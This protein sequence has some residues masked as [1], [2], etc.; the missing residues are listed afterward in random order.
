[1]LHS[2]AW[3]LYGLFLG[4]VRAQLGFILRTLGA[5]PALVPLAVN[6]PFAASLLAVLYVPWFAPYRAR[7]LVAIPRI[8][9]AALLLPAALCTGPFG[10]AV[11]AL[12]A[13]TVHHTAD[14]FYGRLL[15]QL[16][17]AET[18]GRLLSLPLL[19]QA[20]AAA[21]MALAAGWILRDSPSAYRWLVPAGSVLGG[22]AGV[23]I[24][25][26]PVR[27]EAPPRER[28]ALGTWL[29]DVSA[30]RPFLIWTIVYFVTTVGF[31]LADCAK[32]VFF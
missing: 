27:E 29:R 22:M 20:A 4:S 18:R 8:A 28:V 3:L 13:L 11:I 32:P 7:S 1:M 17:P 16:Y 6:G 14:V 30:N 26:F 5:A 24:L 15:S 12:I 10:L 19:V 2:G 31:W 9:G 23:V 21:C 25:R